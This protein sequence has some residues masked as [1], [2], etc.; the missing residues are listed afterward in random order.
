MCRPFGLTLEGR[1]CVVTFESRVARQP[2]R[3]PRLLGGRGRPEGIRLPGEHGITRQTIAQG[4]P[5]VEL[6]LYAAVRF[7]SLH[8]HSGPRMPAGIRPSLRPL[9]QEGEEA[10]QSS[11]EMSREDAKVC[12][13]VRCELEGDAAYSVIASGAKQSRVSPRKDTGL[14][15]SA[16]NDEVVTAVRHA[17]LSR[18]PGLSHMRLALD[19]QKLP[20]RHGRAC[21][22][23]PRLIPRRK[24]RGCPG[25]ARA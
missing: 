19:A 1:S 25:R 11:G 7:P 2:A 10:T 15:R 23:H 24:E 6:H 3:C 5:C 8:S 13:R 17:S 4:R 20:Q 12:R 9:G 21:P 18:A 14:L 22:G 16:R